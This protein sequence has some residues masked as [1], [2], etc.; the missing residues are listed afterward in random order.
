M[1]FIEDRFIKLSSKEVLEY[2][3][4]VII[5]LFPALAHV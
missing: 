5:F 4:S 3:T 1:I 2:L